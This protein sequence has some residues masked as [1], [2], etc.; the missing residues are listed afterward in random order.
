MEPGPSV[1]DPTARLRYEGESLDDEAV[2]GAAPLTLLER[3]YADA[4]AD[5]RIAEPGAMVVAT[6]DARGGPNARTVLLKGLDARGLTFYTNLESTKARELAARPEASLVLP[7]HPMYRQVRVRGRVEQVSREEAAAYF[8]SR[9]RESQLGA[10]ASRQSAPI[11][12]RAELDARVAAEHDRFADAAEVP[13]PPFWGGYRVRPFEVE[14]WVGHASRLHDRFAF[15]S[16][17]GG[18]APLD[19]PAAWRVERRQP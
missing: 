5:E 14:L 11:G 12:S 3:W 17:D 16:A 6:A 13:L 2:A 18:P 9:P 8:G 1:V 19:D 4:M 15:V 7:W 10:W